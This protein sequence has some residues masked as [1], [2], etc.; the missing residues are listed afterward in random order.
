VNEIAPRPHNSGHY[1]IEACAVSQYEAHL[2]AILDLPLS[3]EDLE[4]DRPAIMLNLLG[5][6]DANSHVKVAEAALK[7]PRASVHLYGKGAGRPKRKMGHVTVTGHSIDQVEE[8]IAALIKLADGDRS[9]TLQRPSQSLSP[10]PFGGSKKPVVLVTM[11]SDSDLKVLKA[12]INLLT[13]YRIP[14][15]VT[16]TSAHRTPDRM[17]QVAQAAEGE[18]IKVIIAAAGGAAHLPG[19]M[20]SKFPLPVVGVP[21]RGSGDGK[22]ALASIVQMPPGCPVG[23]MAIN[24]SKNAALYAMKILATGDKATRELVEQFEAKQRD[25][26]LAKAEKLERLGAENYVAS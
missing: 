26:V 5:T 20:A 23:C 8:N 21:V 13:E 14:H 3:A 18:G 6:D 24:N 17:F 2:R 10:Q 4:A 15:R 1:T 9:G 11:G 19:M 25:E 16:I 22:D 12:G 7:V